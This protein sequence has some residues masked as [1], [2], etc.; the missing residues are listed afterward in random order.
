MVSIRGL[1]L[2]TKV[3][4]KAALHPLMLVDLVPESQGAA[5]LVPG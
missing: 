1:L 4:V 5:F 2:A 3:R